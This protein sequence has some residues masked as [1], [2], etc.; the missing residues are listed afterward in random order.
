MLGVKPNINLTSFAHYL[1]SAQTFPNFYLNFFTS[2]CF[3]YYLHFL[4]L[5][6]EHYEARILI[7]SVNA[8]LCAQGHQLRYYFNFSFSFVNITNCHQNNPAHHRTATMFHR[9]QQIC[10]TSWVGFTNVF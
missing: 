6:K 4:S 7:S 2:Y 5:T 3:N 1:T 8:K 10:Q 9:R